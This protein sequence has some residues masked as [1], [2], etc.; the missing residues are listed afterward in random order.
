MDVKLT[1]FELVSYYKEQVELP[2]LQV[3]GWNIGGDPTLV[4]T[5]KTYTELG[6]LDSDYGVLYRKVVASGNNS[7]A[8]VIEFITGTSRLR[9]SGW[10]NGNPTGTIYMYRYKPYFPLVTDY[11]GKETIEVYGSVIEGS[12]EIVKQIES[13]DKFDL[14]ISRASFNLDATDEITT[15]M[16]NYWKP[17]DYSTESYLIR[18]IIDG[19]FYGYSDLENINYDE[20]EKTYHLDV[21]DPIKWLQ[22]NIWSQRIP[23]LG[24]NTANLKN[25][26]EGISVITGDR[27]SHEEVVI[28]VGADQNWNRDYVGGY[29]GAYNPYYYTLDDHMTIEDMVIEILKHYGASIYCDENGNINFVTRNKAS[30]TIYTDDI[31]LEELNKSYLAEQYQGLLII[32]QESG[33]NWE[34]TGWALI[35]EQGGVLKDISVSGSLN[36]IPKNFNY[37][38]LRQELP[39]VVPIIYSLGGSGHMYRVF[40]VRSREQVYE[41]Y[42]ELLR[43][44]EIYETSLDGINYKLLERVRVNEQNYIIRYMQINIS[45]QTTEVRLQKSL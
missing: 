30:A 42:K 2:I 6:Q 7:S 31:L 44:T 4:Q 3:T 8:T 27:S 16:N 14:R 24:V 12:V 32:V 9:I 45:E 43:S 40:G 39:D 36:N 21:Y 11:L 18:V 33:T 23:S 20:I 28:D 19:Y 5:D 22:K 10:S 38:D 15:F 1:A 37:L 26:L 41:D 35:W 13:L 29:Y 17:S 34:Y 25:F